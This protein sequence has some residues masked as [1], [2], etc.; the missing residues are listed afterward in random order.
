MCGITGYLTLDHDTRMQGADVLTAM[1]AALR[2]RGPDAAGHW[3]DRE[4]GIGL[5]M[6]RLAVIDLSTAGAQPMSS[7]CQR[8]MLVFNGEIYN[9]HEIRSRLE[10]EGHAP[11]WSGHSDTETLLAAISA[12]GLSRALQAANGM[13]ALALWDR[14]ARVLSLACDR[15]GEKPL[16]YGWMGKTLLFGSE[17]KALA[18]HKAWAA[19][20]DPN[21][22]SLYLQYSYVPAP[23]SI[24]RG[25]KKL[26]PGMIAAVSAETAFGKEPDLHPYWVTRDVVE[27]AAR[28]PLKI[29]ELQAREE[30][31]RLFEN[32]VALRMEADVPLGAFLSGGFDSTAVVAMMQRQSRRPVRTFTIGFTERAYN[33]APFAKAIAAHLGTGHTELFVSPREAMDV[34]PRLSTIYDEPFGDSSQIPTFLVAQL[35]RQHVTVALSGDGGDELFGGYNRHFVSDR[36]LPVIAQLPQYFRRLLAQAIRSGG[37]KRWER[38]YQLATLGRGRML[39][40]DRTS[41]FADLLSYPSPSDAYHQ[42]VSAWTDPTS[43]VRHTENRQ[44]WSNPPYDGP[45]D[46]SPVERMMYLD[47]V[48]YL[49]GDILTKVDRATMAVSLEGRVPFLDHRLV[50]FAWR[51]PLSHKVA[52][53][54]GK[55]IVRDMVYQHV[56]RHL[57][58]RPKSGFGIPIDDWLRGP[59][60]EWAES[61]LSADSIESTGLLN[62][63]K[64]TACWAQHLSGGRNWQ[65]RL[66]PVL[67]LLSWHREW[68]Q[69]LR[70][71]TLAS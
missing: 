36:L 29:D 12:W 56:P 49:P 39:I 20:I 6:R 70:H 15:F 50:E 3:W 67:M 16:Y 48:T 33:E 62:S 52:G 31:E 42:W 11:V 65:A 27:A 69:S 61:L 47:L 35:A 71:T 64:I 30:F 45:S 34:I 40:G 28:T 54:V 57:M 66:W 7:Y 22:L 24:F 32:A 53:G 60:R 1:T 25:V 17:L 63:A 44:A 10:S 43:M 4:A 2:H 5:G 8:Y 26:T 55:R 9:H 46:L 21:A 59:L 38:A 18:R 19:H 37:S 41:K 58:D 68:A 51:L 13:F 23:F 14:R